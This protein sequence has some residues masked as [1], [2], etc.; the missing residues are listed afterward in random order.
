[1]TDFINVFKKYADFSGRAHRREYWMFTLFNTLI[2]FALSLI[3]IGFVVYNINPAIIIGI[4]SVYG[5]AVIIPSLALTVRRL[6][7][8]DKSGWLFFITFVPA[9]GGII[10]FVFSVLD[11]TP[12]DNQY[13]PD[14]KVETPIVAQAP[15]NPVSPQPQ[16]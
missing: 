1:M 3:G 13:G 16:A 10:L 9:V 15:Q 2:I 4:I 7:D 6:H 5:L 8:I 11:G 12:G 14:P